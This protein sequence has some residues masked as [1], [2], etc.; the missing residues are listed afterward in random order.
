MIANFYGRQ[1]TLEHLRQICYIGITGVSMEGLVAGA[2]TLGFK[3]MA[4]KLPFSSEED[5]SLQ[6]IPLPA[7]AY[8]GQN[9]FVV[10]Y[11]IAKTYLLIAD[12]AQGKIKVSPEQFRQKWIGNEG[13]EGVVLLL[14]PT[15]AFYEKEIPQSK[16]ARSSFWFLFSY[17]R[18][19]RKY[20]S[21]IFAILFVVSLIQY[22]FPYLT[23]GIIDIGIQR[24]Q[25]NFIFIILALQLILYFGQTLLT[26]LLNWIVLHLSARINIML[27]SDFLYK[28]TRL[29]VSYYDN[30]YFGEIIQRLNDHRKVES[31]IS[32][33][34]FS[35]LFSILSLFVYG[36]IL[37]RYNPVICAVYFTG[38]VFYTSWIL[39]F[40]RKRKMIDYEMFN[41]AARNHELLYEFIY[42]M[43]EIKMQNS[44]RKRSLQWTNAQAKLMAINVKSARLMQLQDGGAFF[45]NQFKDIII[46]ILASMLVI[47]GS[48]TLGAL[49]AIQVIIGLLYAP[50]QQLV[51]FLR[52]SNEVKLG[53]DRILEV[54]NKEEENYDVDGP[55]QPSDIIDRDIFFTNVSFRYNPLAPDVLRDVSFC[56]P[57]GKV[58]AIVGASGSGKTTIIKM[59]LGFYAPTSGKVEVGM[60]EIA[61]VRAELW[62]AQCGAV[63]QD[64]YIFSDTI[65]RNVSECDDVPDQEKLKQALKVANIH[66]FVESLA[67]GQDTAIGSRGNG[68]SQGQKQ[69]MLIARAIYKNPSYLFLDEATNALD[70]KNERVIMENLNKFYKGRTVVIV[71]HRLSTVRDADQIIVLDNGQIVE[72]GNHAELV[73][74]REIYYDLIKNQLELG[75]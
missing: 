35:T 22:I 53:L 56:I 55:L 13:L 8:W 11:K 47:N 26:F 37:Y 67:L 73:G 68:L 48:I 44:E 23:K 18:G 7:L 71:A 29:P 14:S 72:Q 27:S 19:Y 43:Q 45:L 50:V 51:T 36:I 52:S 15:D 74:H 6:D 16:K 69:R 28:L 3:T 1:Y 31:F 46:T 25:L 40:I 70:T 61:D 65:A 10:I 66:D 33:S 62:R 39:L 32:S 41:Q 21:L 12:P 57:K 20:I 17:L 34:T 49:L 64:G 59:L 42:G 2:N 4:V 5:S 30:K 63:L 60:L 58:T 75:T 24:R 38:T 54:H 9:H